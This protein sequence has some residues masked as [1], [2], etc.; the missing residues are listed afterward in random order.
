MTEKTKPDQQK[1]GKAKKSGINHS[2]QVE[3][4][5]VALCKKL[6]PD[7][8]HAFHVTELGLKLF[9]ELRTLELHQLDEQCRLLLQYGCLLHDIGWDEGQ[10]KHHKRAFTMITKSDLPLSKEHKLMVALIA[11]FHRK[12]EPA[13]QTEFMKLRPPERESVAKLAAIIRAV[14]VLD[15]F[16]DQKVKIKSVSLSPAG[17]HIVISSDFLSIIPQR[18]LARKVAFFNKAFGIPAL[19]VDKPAHADTDKTSTKPKPTTD[20]PQ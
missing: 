4:Q 14:D 8:A 2:K 18:T 9:D 12:A 3:K 11:R 7:P 13:G 6:D 17:L 20:S 10:E 19:I 5:V 16:H 1:T 15:R